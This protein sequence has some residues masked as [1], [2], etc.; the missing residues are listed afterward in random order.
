MDTLQEIKNKTYPPNTVIEID[1]KRFIGCTFDHCQLVYRG[2]DELSFEG[3]T[4]IDPDWRFEG[5][6]ENVLAFMGDMYESLGDSGRLIESLFAAVRKNEIRDANIPI[7]SDYELSR[8]RIA[9]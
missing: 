8:H 1:G 4:F 7:L 5:P 9:G 3:C 2:T 6:A